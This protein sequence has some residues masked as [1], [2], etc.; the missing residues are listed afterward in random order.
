MARG[1]VGGIGMERRAIG[2]LL[3]THSTDIRYA[4]RLIASYRRNNADGIPLFLV[5]PRKERDLFEA[6]SGN[7]IEILDDESVAPN[8]AMEGTTRLNSGYVNQ[9]IVKLAFWETGLCE[10][11]F[12]LDSDGEFIR[13][14]HASDF[15]Y[16]DSTPYT[17]LVEDND[18]KS[19]PEYYRKYWTEREAAIRLIQ[20][21]VGLEDRRML[22][23]HGFAILSSRVLRSLREKFMAPRG[24]GYL[25]LIEKAPYEFSWYNMWL[26]KDRTIPIHFREPVFKYF[27]YKNQ[28]LDYLRRG[29]TLDDLAR[30]YLGVVINSNYSRKDGLVSYPDGGKYLMTGLELRAELRVMARSLRVLLKRKCARLLGIKTSSDGAMR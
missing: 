3:K 16:D 20:R 19:D 28:H 6:L 15:L 21:E 24:F 29:V 8:L 22:T 14:F 12:C 25:D 2:F 13:E 18:L 11:Y 10:N 1:T 17:V 4:G 27:H 9:E 23:C 7:G 30:G 26:Q 5:C